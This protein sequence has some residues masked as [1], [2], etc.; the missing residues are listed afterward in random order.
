MAQVWSI[1]YTAFRRSPNLALQQHTSNSRSRARRV[2]RSVSV[3][4]PLLSSILLIDNLLIKQTPAQPL[5][6]PPQPVSRYIDPLSDSSHIIPQ[7]VAAVG[8]LYPLNVPRK[9]YKT[10][11]LNVGTVP[12]HPSTLPVLDFADLFVED[13]PAN[14]LT[15]HRIIVVIGTHRFAVYGYLRAGTVLNEALQTFRPSIPWNGEIVTFSLGRRVPVLSRPRAK[16]NIVEEAI[17]RRV[18]YVHSFSRPNVITN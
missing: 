8:V 7:R 3:P 13:T 16:V 14:N 4:T 11:A 12:S 1:T 5:V 15:I 6:P 10:F 9:V 2:K 17:S 18:I